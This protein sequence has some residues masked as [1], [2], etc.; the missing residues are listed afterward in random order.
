MSFLIVMQRL[1]YQDCI[2][3]FLS[4]MSIVKLYAVLKFAELKDSTLPTEA[5]HV[6]CYHFKSLSNFM[7]NLDF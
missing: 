4:C 1:Q 3:I 5:N 6:L 7:E 2:D